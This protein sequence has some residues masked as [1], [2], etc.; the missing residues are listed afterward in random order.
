[1]TLNKHRGIRAGL[2]WEPEIA[3]LI[4]RHNDANVIVF[5]ARFIT[6]DEAAAMLDIFLATEFEGGRHERRIAKIPAGC[7]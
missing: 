4:R 5:P 1:M 2:A 3:G 6:N 7:A